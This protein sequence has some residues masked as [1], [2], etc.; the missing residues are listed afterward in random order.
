MRRLRRVAASFLARERVAR[1]RC[2]HPSHVFDAMTIGSLHVVDLLVLVAYLVIVIYFGHRARKAASDGEG[3]FLAGRKLGKLY[4]FLLN[5]GNSTDAN[6]AVS[7]ASLVYQQGVSGVWLSL[8]T[9][10]MNPYYWFMNLWFRRV[11]LMTVA[12]LFEDRLGSRGLARF[13]AIFQILASVVVTL[14]FGNLISYKISASLMTK[15]Q[16]SWTAAEQQSVAGY[17]E[18]K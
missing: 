1:Q 3:F 2:A 15:P 7:T 17:Q 13:Y 14:G 4:Q 8:Q 16:A 10:F 12:D 9:L 11:R 6:G 5:F 18:M